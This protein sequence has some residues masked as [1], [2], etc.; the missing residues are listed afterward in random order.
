MDHKTEDILFGHLSNASDRHVLVGQPEGVHDIY[1]CDGGATVVHVV[2][3]VVHVK[4]PV[5]EVAA[6]TKLWVAC[7]GVAH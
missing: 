4:E 2:R 3:D 7:L 5:H 6:D 1:A